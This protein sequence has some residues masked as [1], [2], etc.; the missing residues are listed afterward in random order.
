MLSVGL[1]PVQAYLKSG[2]L[3]A[4]AAASK[5]RLAAAP[6]GGPR[7]ARRDCPAGR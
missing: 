2:A 4:L 5:T 3:R 7:R 1:S 6:G